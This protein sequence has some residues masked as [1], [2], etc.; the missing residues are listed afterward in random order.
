MRLGFLSDIHFGYTHGNKAYPDGTNVREQDVYDAAF[1]GLRNLQAANVEAIVDL[2]DLAHT[3]HPKKRSI[4]R[5]ITLIN[6]AGM[7]WFSAG[8]NHTSQRTNSDSHLYELLIDQ[9]PRFSGAFDSGVYFEGIGG[10]LI[11][12][13]SREDI[14]KSLEAIPTDARFIGG[15]WACD[16]ADWPGE[17]IPSDQLH[18][19]RTFLGHWHKRGNAGGNPT[20][21]GA[22]ERF[23]WGEAYNPTGVAVFDTD[24]GQLEFIDHEVREWVDITVTPDNYL[25]DSNYEQVEGAIVRVNVEATADQFSALQLLRVKKKLEP[26]LEYQ[27]RRVGSEATQIEAA[28][29]GSLSLVDGFRERIARAKMPAGIRRA[30]VEDIGLQALT[31]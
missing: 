4:I 6:S 9:C 3:P 14:E 11:P 27:I 13:G 17:H 10:Y 16:D 19:V 28:G 5:L 1:K 26:S 2:G 30:E 23:A 29:P 8:G 22:T 24:T 18:G 7:D 25:E 12:Y 15:H 21:V 20:Y 31:G